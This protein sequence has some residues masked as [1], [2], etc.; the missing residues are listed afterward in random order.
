M[1]NPM[2]HSLDTAKNSENLKR[3]VIEPV[4]M[5]EGHDKVTLLVDDNN[6]VQ[7]CSLHIAEFRKFEH[8]IQGR[9][10]WETSILVQRL[11]G[12]CPVSHYIATDKAIDLISGVTEL[13][14]SAYKLRFTLRANFTILCATFFSSLLTQFTVWF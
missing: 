5:V 1:D 6:Q 3:F 9:P 2:D 12:I 7:Q 4:S 10:Y 11:C 13:T 14:E 8:F